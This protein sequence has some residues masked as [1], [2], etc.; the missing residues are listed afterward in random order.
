MLAV[1]AMTHGRTKFLSPLACV[2]VRSLTDQKFNHVRIWCILFN[3]VEATVGVLPV[4][5][6]DAT[7]DQQPADFLKDSQGSWILE[8]RVYGGSDPAYD[9]QAMAGLPVGVQVV[10]RMWEDEKVLEV[11]GM[12]EELVKFQ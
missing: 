10:G 5:R 12:L 6:V 7:L 8:K 2:S 4:T 1:P 11:M 3:I 9:S